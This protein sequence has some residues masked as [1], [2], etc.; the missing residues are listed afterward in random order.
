[1]KNLLRKSAACAALVAAALLP[2]AQASTVIDFEGD[3]LAGLYLPGQ[4][5]SQGGFTM[6]IGGDFGLVGTTA[7]FVSGA[8]TGNS[9]QFF[10]NSNDGYLTVEATN[11]AAF[12]LDGFSAAFVP[13]S[14]PVPGQTTV[15]VAAG[16]N[17]GGDFV[18]YYF[19]FAPS[20]T[21]NFPFAT[22]NTTGLMENM[23]FVQFF[24][25][26]LDSS[27]CA[28]PTLNNGQFA[29]D[30]VHVTA[31]PEPATVVLVSLG[32]LGLALRT[33]RS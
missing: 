1:M 16:F 10:F 3:A 4:S 22:Y 20:S 17:T 26:V 27:V 24:A 9:T 5:F 13:L 33:R 2:Q 25:C 19:N 31:V 21:G 7:D 15:I 12:S 6:S 18:G 29:L 30:A 11:G 8:P 14:P 23:A 32:L 28:T